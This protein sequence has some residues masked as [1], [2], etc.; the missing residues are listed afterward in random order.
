MPAARP[1]THRRKRRHSA[2][3]TLSMRSTSRGGRPPSS[4]ANSRGA[5][6]SSTARCARS[7]AGPAQMATSEHTPSASSL[8]KRTV[9][10]GQARHTVS[11]HPAPPPRAYLPRSC[12]SCSATASFSRCLSTA[13]GPGPFGAAPPPQRAMYPQPLRARCDGRNRGSTDE[14]TGSSRDTQ[15]ANRYCS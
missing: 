11:H 8:Q 15:E 4:A 12:R 2:G 6:A 13:A 5:R 1:R 14:A 9:T 7:V 3:S 10:T